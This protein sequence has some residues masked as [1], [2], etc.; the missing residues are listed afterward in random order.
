VSVW[1]AAA[2]VASRLLFGVVA[3]LFESRRENLG[4]VTRK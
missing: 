2:I 1:C 3:K 4:M